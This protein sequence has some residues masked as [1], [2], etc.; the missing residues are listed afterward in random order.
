MSASLD[1][2]HNVDAILAADEADDAFE[3]WTLN[4]LDGSA[5]LAPLR[6]AWN[7]GDDRF[8]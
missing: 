7:G 4:E 1:L 2:D 3:E 8:D 5:D 6:S